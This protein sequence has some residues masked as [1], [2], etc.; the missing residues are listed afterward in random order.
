M[1]RAIILVLTSISLYSYSQVGINT[2]NP[3][4]V[5][6][7]DAGSDN[8]ATSSPSID[9]QANDV[10]VSVLG[11][12]GVGTI[13]P[14]AKIDL[15]GTSTITPIRARNMEASSTSTLADRT[16]LHPV[17]IDKDGVMIKQFSP[18]SLGNSYYLDGSFSI[19][20]GGGPV[21]VFTGINENSVVAFKFATNLS[22]GSGSRAM[23]YGQIS[24]SIRNGFRVSNDWTSSGN[25]P[26][27][28]V[29]LVGENTDTLVFYAPTQARLTFTYSSG[30]ISVNSSATVTQTN[31]LIYEGKKLR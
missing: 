26:T 22:F 1:K 21:D 29:S 18:V 25:A 23:I 10:S 6:H 13:S 16:T 5:F 3:Q 8:S 4:G 11:N 20:I 27:E 17:M 30:I 2:V 7:I 24:F 31:V 15:V 9:E 14:S 19:P 28:E 12:I